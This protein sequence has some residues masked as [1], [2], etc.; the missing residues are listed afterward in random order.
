MA[1][2]RS[3]SLRSRRVLRATV[4]STAAV[5]AVAGLTAFESGADAATAS[6]RDAAVATATPVALTAA[7]IM[8][9]DDIRTAGSVGS[10]G[11]TGSTVSEDIA[12][13]SISVSRSDARAIADYEASSQRF[14]RDPAREA[15]LSTGTS[16]V[17]IEVEEDLTQQDPRSIARQ[18]MPEYGMSSSQ[19]GCLD[20]LWVSESDWNMYADNPTSTAYGIPQA[21]MSA[22]DLPADYM[23]NPVTQIEWGLWYIRATYGDACSA[24]SFKQANNWY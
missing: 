7:D 8:P 22:W 1:R 21:L 2:P 3:L 24:W 15:V 13:R 19:F 16:G 12:D 11:S 5:A 23:T 14:V 6:V 17:A 20:A 18:L 4:G 10:T 9:S